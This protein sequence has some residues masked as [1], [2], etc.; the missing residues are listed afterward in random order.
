MGQRLE[1]ATIWMIS[2]E[3]FIIIIIIIILRLLRVVLVNAC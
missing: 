1:N 2:S 3:I